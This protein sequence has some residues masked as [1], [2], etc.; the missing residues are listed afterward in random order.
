MDPDYDIEAFKTIRI[1]TSVVAK[2]RVFCKVHSKSQS[3]TLL[4]M[5]NFFERNAVSPEDHLKDTITELKGHI[6]NRSN[7]IIAII[8]NIEKI[9]HKPTTA[10]LQTLFKETASIEKESE[11]VFEFGNPAL[12]SENEELEY[13][14]NAYYKSQEAYSNLKQDTQELLKK[15]QFTRNNFGIG[16]YRLNIK[17]DVLEAFKHKLDSSCTSP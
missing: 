4:E 17:K 10:I 3:M 13:Y 7:A 6:I 5:L 11:E 8:K 16:H 1:K 15:V 2:F 12:I 9:H 14:K